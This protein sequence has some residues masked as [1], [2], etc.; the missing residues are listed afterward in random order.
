[1][2][3]VSDP[4]YFFKMWREQFMEKVKKEKED[5]QVQYSSRGRR[6]TT[7]YSTVKYKKEKEDHQVQCRTV[8]YKKEMEDHH[9]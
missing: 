9:V 7:R 8:Q 2:S 3:L 1:M 6:R 4:D 5:H